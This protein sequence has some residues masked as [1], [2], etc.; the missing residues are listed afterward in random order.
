MATARSLALHSFHPLPIGLPP[1]AI[2]YSVSF[3]PDSFEPT[4]CN[5]RE[6]ERSK[7]RERER[8]RE[9][10]G[11]REKRRERKVATSKRRNARKGHDG[12]KKRGRE[13]GD[14]MIK[15]KT[16]TRDESARFPRSGIRSIGSFKFPFRNPRVPPFLIPM[17]L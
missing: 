9:R 7:D 17:I 13:R 1:S 12:G 2:L 4:R 16:E 8:E 11:G 15:N 3:P 5:D 10:K 6:I 14:G